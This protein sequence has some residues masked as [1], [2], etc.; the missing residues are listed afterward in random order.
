MKQSQ[1]EARHRDAWAAFTVQLEALEKGKADAE[2]ST[3]F[4]ADYR[5]LCQQLAL[6]ETR[7]YG[8]HLVDRLQGL[9]MRA[10]QQ[11]Y[12]HRSH[13]GADLLGFLLAGF[14]RLVREQ[15]RSVALASLLF[16]GSLLLM[17][18]LVYVFP[19][20]VY[21]VMDP[22]QVAS[23]ES[24]YD[25]DAR[26]I[27]PLSERGSGDDWMMFGHYIMNNIGIAFQTFAGGLLFGLG[28]LFFLLFNGITI[29]A[30]AGHLS[31]IGYT[32]TF[33][34]FVI[35]HGAFELTAITFAG[36]AGLQLG[37]ALLAPGRL[38][39]AEALRRAA[40]E[41]VKLVAGV[42]VM[43]LIAAFIEAYW[44]SIALSATWL[45]YLIG[46]GLWL[47]VGAYFLLVGRSPHAPD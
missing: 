33:W 27:G 12:R 17:G 35:G 3:R 37:W 19:D 40:S 32:E 34:S 9:A 20:L 22:A 46:G 18:G 8:S 42:I 23:M 29:G 39:R 24:M 47:L 14:P 7:G 43:L 15:W 31:E 5:Q 4:A 6:A 44:S 26:R 1:F 21:S 30:V 16:Y 25:P 11:F 10:H 41:S 2:A 13:L 38:P 45:K 36:A 28:S